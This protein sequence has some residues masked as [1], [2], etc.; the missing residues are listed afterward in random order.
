MQIHEGWVD[1]QEMKAFV[2][3]EIWV[4]MGWVDNCNC[5]AV[6]LDLIFLC[7]MTI[8]GLYCKEAW[9]SQSA[10][11]NYNIYSSILLVFSP[12]LVVSYFQIKSLFG[13]AS[14]LY[15]SCMCGGVCIM[16]DSLILFWRALHGCTCWLKTDLCVRCCCVCFWCVVLAPSPLL[17]LSSVWSG[18]RFVLLWNR[19]YGHLPTYR[20]IIVAVASG[21]SLCSQASGF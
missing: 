21:R 17:G 6:L 10:C 3:N 16:S 1:G 7:K 4:G 2:S 15:T 18:R 14:S 8:H 5:K 19:V 13:E 12:A 9:L 11:L 20:L